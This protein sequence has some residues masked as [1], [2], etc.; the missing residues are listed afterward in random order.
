MT[1]MPKTGVTKMLPKKKKKLQ[2]S[3]TVEHTCRNPQQNSS[4]Q[5]PTTHYEVHAS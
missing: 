3:I 5:N 4:K 2:A 1:L